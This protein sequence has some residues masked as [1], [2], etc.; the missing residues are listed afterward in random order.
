MTV[1]VKETQSVG[2]TKQLRI[3]SRTTVKELMDALS[4]VPESWFLINAEGYDEVYLYMRFHEPG[5]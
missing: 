2:A 3:D 4:D 5:E 1:E